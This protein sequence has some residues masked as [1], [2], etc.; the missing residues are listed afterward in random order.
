MH[1]KALRTSSD[2]AHES[3]GARTG[4][5]PKSDDDASTEA[6]QPSRDGRMAG[7]RTRWASTAGQDGCSVLG[8]RGQRL[9]HGP[10]H[11]QAGESLAFRHLRRLDAKL[12]SF[13]VFTDW[14]LML[15]FPGCACIV[16]W[17]GLQIDLPSMP[18]SIRL[19]S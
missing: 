8:S 5:A 7:T 11:R 12:L 9:C 17:A 13:T 14:A 15:T 3:A 19:L 2:Y 4:R 16:R 18:E 10:Q 1:S 6:A